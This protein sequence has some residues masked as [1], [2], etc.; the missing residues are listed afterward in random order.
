MDNTNAIQG[1]GWLPDLP[2]YRDYTIESKEVPTRVKA[3]GEKRSVNKLLTDINLFKPPAN[4]IKNTADL[5][6]SFSPIEN[7]GQLV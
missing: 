5:H 7:Q 2:D 1:M 6:A 3:L 4:A